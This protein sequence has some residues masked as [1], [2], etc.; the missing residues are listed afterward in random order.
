VD[1]GTINAAHEDLI[2]NG[3]KHL[4]PASLRQQLNSY[5]RYY[6]L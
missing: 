4:F 2:S 3:L 1:F 5:Y 6:D